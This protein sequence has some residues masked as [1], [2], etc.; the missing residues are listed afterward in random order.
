MTSILVH[1]IDQ[2]GLQF[3]CQHLAKAGN[4]EKLNEVLQMETQSGRNAWYLE[5]SIRVDIQKYID[6]VQKAW[7][8]SNQKLAE[9]ASL[10]KIIPLQ[11][12][13]ALSFATINSHAI[14]LPSALLRALVEKNI[15][16]PE[17]ALAYALRMRNE[18]QKT[19][20]LAV[21]VDHLKFD[22]PENVL[23][24]VEQIND[25][26]TRRK[27][28]TVIARRLPITEIERFCKHALEVKDRAWGFQTVAD[29][30]KYLPE[31][32]KKALLD[33][34]LALAMQVQDS[35]EYNN[36]IA[37]LS[38]ALT[39]S[40]HLA[41]ALSAVRSIQN[42]Y[43]QAQAL[44]HMVF[45][46]LRQG[47]YE[48]ALA[49]ASE[50]SSEDERSDAA[51][52]LAEKLPVSLLPE[53][54]NL[55]NGIEY[56][57]YLFKGQLA[58]LAVESTQEKAKR[59]P[60]MAAIIEETDEEKDKALAMA[61]LGAVLMDEDQF[62]E[63]AKGYFDQVVEIALETEGDHEQGTL[64]AE[65]APYL[66]EPSLRK[67]LERALAIQEEDW[68]DHALEGLLARIAELGH[69]SEALTMLDEVQ[70]EAYQAPTIAKIVPFMDEEQLRHLVVFTG[71]MH[72]EDHRSEA[73]EGLAPFLSEP[74][75]QEA[76]NVAQ[77]NQ[78][79]ENQ[80]QAMRWLA[81][82]L[83]STERQRFIDGVDEPLPPDEDGTMR[84]SSIGLPIEIRG[85]TNQ[86]AA[87]LKAAAEIGFEGKRGKALAGLAPFL[88]ETLID[89]AIQVAQNIRAV[90]P[91]GE[92]LASLAP[93][94]AELGRLTDA[95]DVAIK[96]E[97]T[98]YRTR[99][100]HPLI[101]QALRLSD[102]EAIVLWQKI[103]V[104]CPTA[105][106]RTCFLI[107]VFLDR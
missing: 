9:S 41:P 1:Q 30:V 57:E 84:E 4:W 95:F 12:L 28:L 39:A 99:A 88:D 43:V 86:P 78:D 76:L 35:Y 70:S 62:G 52:L 5:K 54:D 29:L 61:Q 7:D 68:K 67:I 14:N 31:A 60:N 85:L 50:I 91:Q 36:S 107:L 21:L 82:L 66:P 23:K 16:L 27:A 102:D 45:E 105:R 69:A 101:R 40:G 97:N 87:A 17:Q 96:I 64:F 83:P 93:R 26:D 58:L 81:A 80:I 13:Y 100:L 34:A 72:E 55:L 59:I 79:N 24:S 22:V 33:R 56:A 18:L 46:L 90:N 49:V 15:W 73:L 11:C 6:D 75:L 3:L 103:I 44:L 2:Y 53:V 94:L 65:L 98:R 47:H 38:E 74:L 25:P 92:A 89:Q 37:D 48:A 104:F 71:E 51:V 42:E 63:L 10:R 19:D 8:L 32:Q 106:V 77:L 20:A